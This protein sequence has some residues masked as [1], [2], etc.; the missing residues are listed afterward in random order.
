MQLITAQRGTH[1]LSTL[2]LK[3]SDA[4]YKRRANAVRTEVAEWYYLHTKALSSDRNKI[5]VESIR[6]YQATL[7]RSPFEKTFEVVKTTACVTKRALRRILAAK[8]PLADRVAIASYCIELGGYAFLDPQTVEPIGSHLAAAKEL[9]YFFTPP[10]LALEM[11]RSSLSLSKNRRNI[12]V[13]DPACGAGIFLAFAVLLSRRVKTVAGVELDP[14]TLELCATVLSA[15]AAE[16]ERAVDIVL[17]QGDFLTDHQLLC[18]DLIVMNPPYGRVRYISP[19]LS[20]KETAHGLDSESAAKLH[21][22]LQEKTLLAASRLKRGSEDRGHPELSRHF[23]LKALS[24]VRPSGLVAALTTGAWLA[25]RSAASMRASI[26]ETHSLT[27]LWTFKEAAR[28][29]ST[30]NQATAVA[31][32]SRRLPSRDTFILRPLLSDTSELSLRSEIVSRKSLTRLESTRLPQRGGFRLDV[33]EAI[34]QAPILGNHTGIVNRRGELDLTIDRSGISES[35]TSI[36]L[37]RGDHIREFSLSDPSG[38]PK[39]GFVSESYYREKLHTSAKAEHIAQP[40]VALPQC[41][42]AEKKK[43]IQAAIVPAGSVLANS[44]NYIATVPSLFAAETDSLPLYAAAMNSLVVEWYFRLFNSNNHVANYEID[45]LP[46]VDFSRLPAKTRRR[47][48]QLH[49]KCK[50]SPWGLARIELERLWFSCYNLTS[51]HVR[52][53]L[54]DFADALDHNILIGLMRNSALHERA[55]FEC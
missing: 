17:K 18:P 48:L 8:W 13:L 30:V 23:L 20:N 39:H 53:I 42:Y 15:V 5:E 46:V 14:F 51:K 36:R 29:F 35:A 37:V 6:L 3:S 12:T 25:D 4:E 24:V 1:F 22:R 7:E 38:S 33:A 43:R 9:G 52:C 26:L 54:Y 47:M 32:I 19:A 45:E 40:R 44:C 11:V 16:A 34:K 50:Q 10:S 2:S 28:L 27:E 31:F 49:D 55:G 21:R 41:S